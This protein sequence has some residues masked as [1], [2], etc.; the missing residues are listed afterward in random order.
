M[1]NPIVALV[2]R[3]NVGKSTLFNRITRSRDAL[4]DNSPGVTRDRR[5]GSASWDDIPF[6]VVDTGGFLSEDS[7][8]FSPIIRSQV[9][10]AV[11]DADIVVMVLD[12]KSGPSPFD[13]DMIR[14]L[15]S[16][17]KPVLYLVNKIDDYDKEIH[18]YDFHTLG[19]DTLYPVSAEHNYGVPDFLDELVRLFPRASEGMK[20]GEPDSP[21]I[22]L[23]VVG[24]PNVGKS[25]LIN[26]I[27]GK[28]RLVVSDVPGTTRDSIDSPFTRNGRKYLLIDTA[29]IRK[30]ARVS[31]KL[32]K[33]S[34]IK[35][36]QSLERCDIA[37][38]VVDASE[39]ILDQDVHIAGYAAERKCGCV[40]VLNKWDLVDKQTTTVGALTEQLRDKARFLQFAPAVTLSALTG[41]RVSGIF[42]LVEDVFRQFTTRVGTGEINRMLE[43]ATTTKEPSLFQGKRLKFYYMTQVSTRPPSFVAFVN[44]PEGV[45]FSYER[46]LINR[47]RKEFRLDKT[48]IHLMFRE[49]S[50][51]KKE[52]G[53][54]G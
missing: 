18:L 51:R 4:V 48:P 20:T 44:R 33:L 47:I 9:M 53:R 37:L 31:E 25:S 12:G 39:G 42:P 28:D 1:K 49:R 21:V 32:E 38:I 41:Q 52:T 16:V 36:L 35:S 43:K 50:G 45:H 15:R 24:R 26:R 17:E 2:G 30:K 27:L 19:I 7:D 34:I 3:P 54:K 22:K 29:G 13:T 10:Q 23:A 46:Y 6:T 14:I 40:F 8:L 5:Y 11:A